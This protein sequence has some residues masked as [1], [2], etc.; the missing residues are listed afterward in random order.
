MLRCFWGGRIQPSRADRIRSIEIYRPAIV[1][2]LYRVTEV[3]TQSD[4]HDVVAG[5]EVRGGRQVVL[6]R[7]RNPERSATRRL[8]AIDHALR[9]LDHPGVVRIVEFKESRAD[10]WL[11]TERVP[12]RRL[13][14]WWSRLPL[15]PTARFEDRWRHIAPLLTGML[16][17]LEALH[18]AH[19][20]HLDLKPAN[21]LVD[22]VGVPT[23][24][25]FGFPELTSD[26]APDE[27][28]PLGRVGFGAPEL[29]DGVSISRLADQFSL[30]LVLYLLLT[31]RRALAGLTPAELAHAYEVGRVQPLREWRPET[32]VDVEEVV[33]RMLEWD[34]EKRFPSIAAVREAL[35]NRLK[36][37][38]AHVLQPWAVRPPEFVG[39]E[40]FAAV[41]RKRLLELKTG[42]AS[43]VRMVAAAGAGKTRLLDAWAEQAADEGCVVHRVSCLP[44]APRA[45][46]DGWFEPPPC[47]PS[48][49]PPADL[50]DQALARFKEPTVLLLDDLEDLDPSAWARVLR[51]VKAATDGRHAL[52]VVLAGRNVP[53]GTAMVPDD[54]PRIFRV[55]LPPLNPKAVARLLRP[56]SSDQ[57]DLEVRD[58]AAE[59]LCRESKGNPGRL[60]L[61]LL[62]DEAGGRLRR[63]RGRWVPVL[64]GD[65]P[66][67]TP[68]PPLAP[69]V[70]AWMKGLGEPLEVQLLLTCLPLPGSGILE[71]L[72]WGMDEGLLSFRL[73]GEHWYLEGGAAAASSRTE[74]Y[75]VRETHGRAGTWLS[76]NDSG[77]G[78]ASERIADHH[79]QAGEMAEASDAY[80]DAAKAMA[81][82]GANSDSRR[83][84]S[85]SATFRRSRG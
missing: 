40:P 6:K 22:Q 72:G 57:E 56:E 54:H 83:L 23:L 4:D 66:R 20:G 41:F 12:G 30:G 63:E 47:D 69:H 17:A 84:L 82:I 5:V 13:L 37:A 58:G 25:D 16:D 71:T 26:D 42:R 10:A 68:Q 76:N 34:P 9:G 7:L 81:A 31:G 1:N 11:V 21:I 29:V 49:P 14:D 64:G 32:P 46:L 36:P 44:G 59:G 28:D 43:V 61:L 45:V 52:L 78:L 67:M 38:P 27:G 8:S 75:S 85:L 48:K 39:R 24:V 51:V 15:K 79:R 70:L 53:D 3:M 19:L 65:E 62:R 55:S 33:L 77:S 2:G 18:G 73:R 74:L 35:A 50:V 80:K 60:L